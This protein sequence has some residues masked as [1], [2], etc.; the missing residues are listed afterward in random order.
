MGDGGGGGCERKTERKTVAAGTGSAPGASG[1][2]ES[3]HQ[4]SHRKPHSFVHVVQRSLA[5]QTCQ[6]MC[7]RARMCVYVSN[8]YQ[9]LETEEV[10]PSLSL[11]LLSV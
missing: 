11:C 2:H 8:G 5:V 6:S 10:G 9:K 7:V 1:G 4:R 3:D